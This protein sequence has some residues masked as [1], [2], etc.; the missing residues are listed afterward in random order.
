MEEATATTSTSTKFLVI[1]LS[2]NDVGLFCRFLNL[3]DFIRFSRCSKRTALAAT[4]PYCWDE[5]PHLQPVSLE[6]LYVTVDELNAIDRATSTLRGHSFQPRLRLDGKWT[7]E[8]VL[9]AVCHP[10]VQHSKWISFEASQLPYVA[11]SE[12]RLHGLSMLMRTASVPSL[13]PNFSTPVFANLSQLSV[14]S[15]T[16]EFHQSVLPRSITTLEIRCLFW[17]Q[18][19]EGVP[20]STDAAK[21]RGGT[22]SSTLAVELQTGFPKL[23][24]FILTLTNFPELMHINDLRILATVND[25]PQIERLDINGTISIPEGAEFGAMFTKV[26]VRTHPHAHA[27]VRTCAFVPPLRCFLWNSSASRR[28]NTFRMCNEFTRFKFGI[29]SSSIVCYHRPSPIYTL[30]V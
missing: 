24:R 11:N 7:E 28:C 19:F 23:T 15:T 2:L 14:D 22:L 17:L 18:R 25:L 8:T 20:L 13:A 6:R 4:T 29:S 26:G 3:I 30:L 5:S 10:I 16:F 21:V 9:T 12:L 1:P 27:L